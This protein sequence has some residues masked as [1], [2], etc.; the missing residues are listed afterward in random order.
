M[1]VWRVLIALE[2]LGL[3][4]ALCAQAAA[5]RSPVFGAGVIAGALS[6]PGGR[7]DQLISVTLQYQPLAW[8]SV[9][10]SPGFGRSTYAGSSESGLTDVPVIARATYDSIPG[11]W[12]PSGW[13]ALYTTLQTS[14][15]GSPLGA[16]VTTVGAALGGGIEPRTGTFLYVDGSRP[17][18]S[19]ASNGFVEVEG[20]RWIGQVTG[21]LALSSE[22]G[23]VDSGTVASRSIAA[24][25]VMWL[26]G[27]MMLAIDVTHGLTTSAP[28][29]SVSV[30]VGTALGG[31]SP[32]G[33]ASAFS[34]LSSLFGP[35]IAVTSGNTKT[36]G[37]PSAD[38]KRRKAC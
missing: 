31:L 37:G 14:S 27:P 5:E 15:N 34:R 12:S 4:A 32:S 13:G 1:L 11:P 18:T 8:L 24:G 35:K 17:L 10:A 38:C 28:T 36:T 23:R 22:V 19:G 26:T 25:M 29:W 16:G 30:G 33:A 6:F 9:S 3:P 2:F 7:A 21:T 20:A